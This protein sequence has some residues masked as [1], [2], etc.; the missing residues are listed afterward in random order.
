MIPSTDRLTGDSPLDTSHV[1]S[2]PIRDSSSVLQTPEY[3]L[4]VEIV[5]DRPLHRKH[6]QLNE[7][8]MQFALL[9]MQY[10]MN[11]VSE[12]NE[13]LT[14]IDQQ[15]IHP[16]DNENKCPCSNPPDINE[17]VE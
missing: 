15:G 1:A 14:D 16:N 11:D 6:E 12:G 9:I 13:L 5:K 10:Q 8:R 3:S 2:L 17:Q 4:A 7:Q